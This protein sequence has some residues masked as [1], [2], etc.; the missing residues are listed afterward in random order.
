KIAAV[1][2]VREASGSSLREAVQFVEAQ[3]TGARGR[4]LKEDL[5]RAARGAQP[6]RI[7]PTPER[8]GAQPHARNEMQ[9]MR[10]HDRTPTVEMGDAPGGPR[11]LLLVACLLALAAW[12]AL[13]GS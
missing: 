2:L 8:H 5:Q 11:W 3:A 7:P 10:A 4:A 6:V 1:K 12:L 13:T 9:A